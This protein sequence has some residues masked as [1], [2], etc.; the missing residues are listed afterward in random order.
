M[1]LFPDLKREPGLD[2]LGKGIGDGA[3]EVAENLHC[4]LRFDPAIVDQIIDSVDE[5]LA[6]ARISRSTVTFAHLNG[7]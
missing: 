6:D 2:L 3:V 5:C 4:Q 7:R 1:L